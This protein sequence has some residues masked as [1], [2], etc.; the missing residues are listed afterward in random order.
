VCFVSLHKHH[1]PHLRSHYS[2]LSLSSSSR[3]GGLQSICVSLLS[4]MLS[5]RTTFPW[6][7][8]DCVWSVE[9]LFSLV[10]WL[11]CRL[12]TIAKVLYVSC[13]QLHRKNPA[14]DAPRCA[15]R[16]FVEIAA[17]VSSRSIDVCESAPLMRER[18]ISFQHRYYFMV[19]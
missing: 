3:L 1:S 19:L 8:A 4:L 12:F 2:P 9:P 15:L 5:V 6:D 17:I 11:H 18:R 16:A 14:M 7:P 10:L 13:V